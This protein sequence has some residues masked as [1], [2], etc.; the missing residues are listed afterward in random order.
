MLLK[1]RK[2]G[3]RAKFT[4]LPTILYGSAYKAMGFPVFKRMTAF[5]FRPK[6]VLKIAR[7]VH[8]DVD[9]H[10]MQK[11]EARDERREKARAKRVREFVIKFHEDCLE[12]STGKAALRHEKSM[13]RPFSRGPRTK[14]TDEQD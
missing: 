3:P 6:D 7:L 9:K 14:L 13:H 11:Q 4:E 12:V 1:S 5:Y 10:M 2:P 8:G